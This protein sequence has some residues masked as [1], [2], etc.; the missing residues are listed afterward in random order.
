MLSGDA[1]GPVLSEVSGLLPR[2]LQMLGEQAGCKGSPA[3]VISVL[4]AR[5]RQPPP[6]AAR[7]AP[8]NA[9][10]PCRREASPTAQSQRIGRRAGDMGSILG[11]ARS[12]GGGNGNPSGILA[13][14]IPCTEEP[15]GLQSIGSQSQTHLS[16]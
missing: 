11:S 1:W 3:V 6:A 10:V 14:R 16:N 2:T 8:L 15:G 9:P 5:G 4:P 13:W 7:C 12:P